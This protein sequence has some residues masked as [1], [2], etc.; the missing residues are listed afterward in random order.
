MPPIRMRGDGRKAQ[1]PGKTMKRLLSYMGQYRLT[2]VVV[3]LSIALSAIAQ[4]A[5]SKSLGY[6]VDDYIKP[7]VGV[8]TP[9]L[10]GLIRFLVLMAGIYLVGM[11]AS[12]LCEFLMVKV[13][14]GT[15]KTIRDTLFTKMQ[16]LPVRYFDTHPAGDI[17][18][19][20]TNDI[21]TLRQMIS[22]AICQCCGKPHGRRHVKV[23]GFGCSVKLFGHR[24]PS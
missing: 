8:E 23:N 2:L 11:I 15:Q 24:T 17:M 9:D 12:F 5:S 1:N 7:L 3:V 22:Q 13:G 19:C 4:V 14:Q 10:S 21:E 18:S 6:L 20:Y 16:R